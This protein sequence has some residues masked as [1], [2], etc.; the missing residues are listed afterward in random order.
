MQKEIYKILLISF[1]FGISPVFGKEPQVT[2]VYSAAE[3][4]R[5]SAYAQVVAG[6]EKTIKNS[7]ALEVSPES[8]D[9]QVLID[10]NHPDKVI[11]LGRTVVEAV[12]NTSY[13]PQILAGLMYFR[14]DNFNGV[15]LA[16]DSRFLIRAVGR[17]VPSIKR[18]FIIQQADFRTIDYVADSSN[19][20]FSV[21]VR[22]GVDSLATI[23]LLAHL[24]DSEAISTD[25]VFI[26]AN[27]PNNILY[28]VAKVAWDKRI[29]LFSTN[30]SHLD[31]GA[32]MVAFPDNELLGVQLGRLAAQKATANES[33]NGIS[34]G[35]NRRVAQHL[36]VDFD[37]V[38]LNAF[39]LKIK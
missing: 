16:L 18:I 33:V 37:Q 28:E 32:L 1:I 8:D 2:I 14:N 17:L 23:R 3:A 39:A 31:N 24:L 27:L 38:D 6:V 4:L 9:M 12:N 10:N 29:M 34:F 30:L 36:N 20:A 35:L 5:S 13:R 21:E 22:E 11:A 19:S 25:A 7:Q 26:P 15:S